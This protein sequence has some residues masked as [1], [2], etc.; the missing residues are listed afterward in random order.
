MKA[1]KLVIISFSF[2]T[3]HDASTI[4]E[5]TFLHMPDPALVA[6]VAVAAVVAAA[7]AVVISLE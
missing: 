7:A 4:P 1:E 3:N 5:D 6:A 2:T